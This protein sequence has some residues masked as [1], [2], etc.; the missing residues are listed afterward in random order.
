MPAGPA[1]TPA[2]TFTGAPNRRNH[3]AL[4]TLEFAP[5]TFTIQG[6]VKNATFAVERSGPTVES[7]ALVAKP[8]KVT[9][10]DLGQLARGRY[11]LAVA[12][13]HGHSR[14][15]LLDCRFRVR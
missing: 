1:E 3:Q 11:T 5:G 7:G 14:R 6:T 9:V 10:R 2:H 4:C 12:S 13:G 15:M 8:G